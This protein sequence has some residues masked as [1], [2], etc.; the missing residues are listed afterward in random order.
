[1]KTSFRIRELRKAS[2]MTQA[3]LASRLEL[4]SASTVT[5]WE[6]GT[7]MPH[8]AM[9]PKLAEVMNC[10]VDELYSGKRKDGESA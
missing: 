5:M 7:R 1:M 8:S 4:K 9:L 2:G 10:T 3:E 6:N